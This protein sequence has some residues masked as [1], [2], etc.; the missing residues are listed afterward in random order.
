MQTLSPRRE[1]MFQQQVSEGQVRVATIEDA[2]A[3][4]ARFARTRG[5]EG[6]DGQ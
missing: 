3:S 1:Q 4:E 6:A 5:L 2:Q